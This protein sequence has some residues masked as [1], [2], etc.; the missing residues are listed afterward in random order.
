MLS[1]LRRKTAAKVIPQVVAGSFLLL[2]CSTPKPVATTPPQPGFSVNTPL[3][4]IAAD[5]RGRA[6]LMQDVPGVMNNPKYPLFEDMSLSQIAIISN[7]RVS[8]AKLDEVQAD[9]GRLA[10]Q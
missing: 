8:Q 7:G 5:D 10:G 2:G 6:V 1:I 3:D 4:V 9:L